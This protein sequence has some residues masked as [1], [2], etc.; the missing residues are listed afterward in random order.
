MIYF[1]GD[2]F[3][4]TAPQ[5]VDYW[6]GRREAKK[7]VKNLVQTFKNNKK[8]QITTIWGDYGNGKT[9]T[10]K[11]IKHLFGNSC[12]FLYSPYSKAGKNFGEL[13]KQTFIAQYDFK[14]FGVACKLIYQEAQK[15]KNVDDAIDKIGTDIWGDGSGNTWFEFS[16]VVIQVGLVYEAA[17][18][19]SEAFRDERMD[20]AR[21]WLMGESINSKE[22]HELGVSSNA[23]TDE[24]FHRLCYI[25]IRLSNSKY[26]GNKPVVWAL[27][28]CQVIA[29]F[30]KEKMKPLVPPKAKA[31]V[32]QGIRTVFDYSHSGL[33][34]LLG[35]AS[36]DKDHISSFFVPDIFSRLSP[37][38]IKLDNF[39]DDLKEPLEFIHDIINDPKFKLR[40]KEWYPFQNEKVVIEILEKILE[41]SSTFTPR[42]IIKIFGDIVAQ[43]EIKKLEKIDAKFIEK[44]FA[45]RQ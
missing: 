34:I 6:A 26:G 13:Y 35:L 10:M 31:Q 33:L 20:I 25:L 23:K 7:N 1:N 30:D 36:A 16:N 8:A 27:D 5:I 41:N 45:G 44:Y 42:A 21:R 39:S 19:D 38:G 22:R 14:K 12:I 28:D 24:Q 11:Y 18:N 4:T 15:S 43:A 9:H 17:G 2:P 3:P 40:G 32:Q 29:E 37:N